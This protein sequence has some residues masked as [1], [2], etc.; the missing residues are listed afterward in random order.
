MKPSIHL[1][2]CALFGVVISSVTVSGWAYAS[3]ESYFDMSETR[4]ANLVPFPKWTGMVSRYAKQKR[5][6]DEDCGK[7]RFHPCE[8]VQWKD[9]ITSIQSKPLHEQLEEVNDWGNKH[10]YVEDQLNWGIGDYWET[11]YEFMEVS[12]DCED[13][14]ITKYYSLR[15]LG[16]SADKLRIMVVQDFNL[17]GIIHAILGVYDSDGL[18]ILDNQIKQ[19]MPAM[20]IYH[21]RP[22]FGINE[23]AWWA[24]TPRSKQ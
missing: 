2:L 9:F 18:F 20:K 12:G 3:E 16:I 24:Y 11:P 23:T 6:P 13:Y 1:I 17:G 4:S 19:V 15:A 7:V 22:I 10:P 8:I 5:V 21:Y 14:A